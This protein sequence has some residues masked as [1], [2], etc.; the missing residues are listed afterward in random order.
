MICELFSLLLLR[1][2]EISAFHVWAF[3]VLICEAMRAMRP[4]DVLTFPIRQKERS[5]VQ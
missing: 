1:Q 3:G 2:Q 5:G 4:L